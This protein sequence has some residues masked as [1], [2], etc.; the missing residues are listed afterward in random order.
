MFTHEVF[1]GPVFMD[2]LWFLVLWSLFSLIRVLI[3]HRG[4]LPAASHSVPPKVDEAITTPG[5]FSL[6]GSVSLVNVQEFLLT[7][8]ETDTAGPTIESSNGQNLP[9]PAT[10]LGEHRNN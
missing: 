3:D 10:D 7:N 2:L 1:P 4:H 9:Q 6:P 8:S 5:S